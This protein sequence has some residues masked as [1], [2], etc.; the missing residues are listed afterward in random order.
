MGDVLEQVKKKI[1][2]TASVVIAVLTEANQ[3]VYLEIGYAWGK[4]RPTILLVKKE[5][6]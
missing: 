4:G 6:Q 5:K 1:E 2:E 3:N